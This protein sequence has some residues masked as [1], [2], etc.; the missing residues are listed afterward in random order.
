MR[1]IC[2]MHGAALS[3]MKKSTK[4][5]STQ[6]R[7]HWDGAVGRVFAKFWLKTVREHTHILFLHPHSA[8]LKRG[9]TTRKKMLFV[10]THP[11]HLVI[12]D[13]KRGT[14]TV[15]GW[16]FIL[17]YFTTMKRRGR[18]TLF[19]KSIAALNCDTSHLLL[20]QFPL[21]TNPFGIKKTRQLSHKKNVPVYAC[22][23]FMAI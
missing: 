21:N 5:V 8:T 14:C 22:P 11:F 6:C 17:W 23:F 2:F 4:H 16:F 15:R 20:L 3:S 10:S 9:R 18:Q 1:F 7:G 19:R 12:L 13:R